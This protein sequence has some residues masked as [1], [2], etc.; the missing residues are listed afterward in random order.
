ME[1]VTLTRLCLQRSQA[2]LKGTPGIRA[3]PGP[4]ALGRKLVSL[5]IRSEPGRATGGTQPPD[6]EMEA[7]RSRA[8]PMAE[9]V[10]FGRARLG[11][12]FDVVSPTQLPSCSLNSSRHLGPWVEAGC[13]RP[14]AA[15][16]D[17][18]GR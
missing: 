12:A 3:T 9:T 11:S 14:L 15:P 17:D 6:E 5:R 1:A 7:A 16:P 2:L 10:A 18:V 8:D 13:R 4:G